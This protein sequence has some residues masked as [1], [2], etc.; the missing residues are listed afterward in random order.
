MNWVTPAPDISNM[1]EYMA[2]AE[3]TGIRYIDMVALDQ[4]RYETDFQKLNQ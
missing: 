3:A 1:N 4:V 2:I